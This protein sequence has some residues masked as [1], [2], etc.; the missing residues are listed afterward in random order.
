MYEAQKALFEQLLVRSRLEPT[1]V[2]WWLSSD[3]SGKLRAVDGRCC[4]LSPT[5]PAA[6][7]ISR[8]DGV[9]SLIAQHYGVSE[10]WVVGAHH[11][12]G[13]RRAV[14]DT[15]N[16]LDGYAWGQAMREKYVRQVRR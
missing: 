5:I 12:F 10:E 13:N 4:P 2:G 9:F 14:S 15:T 11:G 3:S 8:Y 1:P 16:F 6:K 7:G